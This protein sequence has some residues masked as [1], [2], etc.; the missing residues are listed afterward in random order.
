ML[1]T[2]KLKIFGFKIKYYFLLFIISVALPAC[3]Q[4]NLLEYKSIPSGK[5]TIVIMPDQ[6][7]AKKE[8]GRK[9]FDEKSLHTSHKECYY[10]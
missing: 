3:F 6:T 4:T 9:L 2:L 8:N 7:C 10:K 5:H 1:K